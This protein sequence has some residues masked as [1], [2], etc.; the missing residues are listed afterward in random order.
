M[1]GSVRDALQ[2][3]G[4][5]GR[6]M[7]RREDNRLLRGQGLFVDDL[8][9]KGCLFLDVLRSPYPAGQITTLE[10]SEAVAMAG[11]VAV[12]TA[13]DLVLAADC[14]VNPLLPNAEIAAMEPLAAKWVRAAGQP[15]AA[16]IAT[17]RDAARAATEAIWLEVDDQPAPPR[18]RNVAHWGQNLPAFE[19]PVRASVS[20]ALVAPFAMEPRATFAMPEAGG[21]AVWLSTQTPQRGRDDLCAMLGLARDKIR[22][23]APDVGGAFG[24]KASLM[25]EDFLTA[26][27]ALTLQRPVKWAATRSDEFLAATQGRGAASHAEMAV[28][29]SG[30]A[31]GLRA[32]FAFPLGHWMPYSA[33]APIRNAG[34][35]LPGPYAIPFD[36]TAT[37]E[38]SEGPA[39]NIY[40]G[41]GRPEAAMILE[42][43]MDRAAQRLG[44]DPM[45]I[46]RLNVNTQLEQR[47][48][49]P[50]SGNFLGLLER[51]EAETGYRAL[52]AVQSQRRAKGEICG[53]GVALYVEP[54]GQG[55]E[56]ASL[57]LCEDG[58][59]L[60]ITGS[61]A[62]GQGRET[63]MAQIVAQALNLHPV[64]V[65]VSQGDTS[66]AP[67]GIG[68][69]ASRSTAI[70][71][72]AM[73][74]AASGLLTRATDLA[75]PL[76]GCDAS[77]VTT[78]Q[79][80]LHGDGTSLAWADL[81]AH[82]GGRALVVNI[83]HEAD[84]EAWASG[85]ILAEVAIDAETGVLTIE[86]ITWVDDAGI[87]I[88]PLLV[89]GQLLGGAAQGIGA[90]TMERMV[91][92][93]GQLQTGSLMD[94]ALPRASD[95][96]PITLF[97]QPTPSP[98]N[99]L[100]VKGVG[101]AGCIGIPAAILNAVMDA[102][103]PETPDLSLPLT[104]EK[105]WRALT[106]K[107]L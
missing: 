50:C 91:Y 81:A 83:R 41:A 21:L 106:G 13:D 89:Q 78:D 72:A 107:M 92:A 79:A 42:R 98:A 59:F 61:S 15:V 37:A 55:W 94:Y 36:V 28:D 26:F 93:D 71:G 44:I 33:L 46:R 34:R 11:V 85:A 5:M 8:Q 45:D 73:W 66:L 88:N 49:A 16:I 30:R 58:S 95:M 77:A 43:L 103:P 90:A 2:M 63:A 56:T 12:F 75:A 65:T 86:R 14:A 51:L 17:S 74:R 23:I 70:G 48:D 104:S 80:G 76:L 6:A 19:N 20:H 27:A 40:R 100:G 64:Q 7:P 29:Q 105:L 1:D 97:S 96:P 3:N 4:W 84:A 22:V 87:V 99:P 18:A 52:R 101:E 9:V 69:L 68:A 25:P 10:I 32:Q 35:I 54:C 57:R 62:Q 60:A 53:L 39:V 67:E 47:P 24:G 38:T 102:L 31:T 82:L